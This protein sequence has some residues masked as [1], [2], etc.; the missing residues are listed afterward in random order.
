MILVADQNDGE[1][2]PRELHGFQMDFGDQG[3]GRVDNLEAALAGLGP[4]LG[5]NAVGAEDNPRAGGHFDQFF[6]EDS[7]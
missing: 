1:T 2:L 7:P 4:N 6:H 3:T 5:R